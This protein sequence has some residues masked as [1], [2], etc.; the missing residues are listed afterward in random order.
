MEEVQK[1]RSAWWYVGFGCLGTVVFGCLGTF[2][3]T[4][5]ACSSAQQWADDLKDQSKQEQKARVAANETLGGVPIGY[6][7]VFAFGIPF[8]IDMIV[9]IDQKPEADAGAVAFD[10]SF[11]FM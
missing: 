1:K 3:V 5:L 7:P 6:Y 9:F 11:N 10:R 2:I 4:K 8:V